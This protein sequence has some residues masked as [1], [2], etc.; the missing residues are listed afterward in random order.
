MNIQH[1]TEAETKKAETDAV[2]RLTTAHHCHC[3]AAKLSSIHSNNCNSYIPVVWFAMV[4]RAGS[5]L[6]IIIAIVLQIKHAT[7]SLQNLIVLGIYI[8]CYH[9]IHTVVLQTTYFSQLLQSSL[10]HFHGCLG[11]GRGRPI[12]RNTVLHYLVQVSQVRFLTGILMSWTFLP[13]P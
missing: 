6:W 2:W 7:W 1:R 11:V 13:T 4:F 10:S 9:E 8:E 3:T 5:C 12:V